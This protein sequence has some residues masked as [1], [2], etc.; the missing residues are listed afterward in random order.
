MSKIKTLFGDLSKLIQQTEVDGHGQ[1]YE[2]FF[3]KNQF[4]NKKD[5]LEMLEYAKAF[6]A[7]P[8]TQSQEQKS[9]VDFR[10]YIQFV[11]CLAEEIEEKKKII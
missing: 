11:L 9:D 3:S 10:G 4:A 5:F 2:A 6:C 1:I 8:I 7:Y